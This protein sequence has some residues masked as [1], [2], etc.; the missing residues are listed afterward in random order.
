MITASKHKQNLE[1]ILESGLIAVIRIQSRESLQPIIKALHLGGIKAVEIT[2]TTPGAMEAVREASQLYKDKLIIGAGTV[3]DPHTAR[4]AILAGAQFIVSPVFHADVVS[5][6]R[7]YSVITVPG[8]YTPTEI[9][10]AWE[11]G[12]DIVK[13][14]PAPS[15]GSSYFKDVLAPLPQVRLLPTGISLDTIEEYIKAG[16]ACLSAGATL[17][18]PQAVANGDWDSIRDLTI[19][20]LAKIKEARS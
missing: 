16:V 12:A 6:C 11:A 3:L 4:T 20:F 19:A 10:T 13:V 9:L 7:S 14:F 15:L 5:L 1:T 17:I 2:M 18:T 8:T